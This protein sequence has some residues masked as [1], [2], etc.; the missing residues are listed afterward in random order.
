M[1]YQLFSYET[2]GGVRAG[3]RV[4][5]AHFDLSKAA[6]VDHRPKLVDAG[7]DKVIAAW[8]EMSRELTQLV[9]KLRSEPAMFAAAALNDGTLQLAA[10]LQHPGTIYAAGANYRDHVEAMGRASGRKLVLDPKAEGIPP[11]HFIKGGRGNLSAHRGKV[12]YPARTER[13]DWEAELAVVIGREAIGVRASEALDHVA[14]YMC[15][16][17]LSARDIFVRS[18]V[19]P[20]SPFHY[21]W[22]SHKCFSGSCPLGPVFTPAAHAGDPEALDIKLWLNGELRQDSNTR[23]HLYG[24]AEQISFLSER[25]A[26]L[27]GDVLLTGTPAGVGMESGTFLQRGD[28]MKVWIEGL[29]ELET[30]IV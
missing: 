26:L 11:W 17:D 12:A 27:P 22:V 14:G 21:D 30:Q 29:G 9:A 1:K 7:I 4:G 13:L 3:I 24:V 20:A 25:I 10:P 8:D 18:K 2:S 16:N 5:A 15:A 6:F 23:N 19:D 28:V